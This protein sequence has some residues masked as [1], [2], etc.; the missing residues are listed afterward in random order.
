MYYFFVFLFISVKKTGFHQEKIRL[1]KLSLYIFNKNPRYLNKI[2]N[3]VKN[4]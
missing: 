1:K 3:S 4:K 2:Q